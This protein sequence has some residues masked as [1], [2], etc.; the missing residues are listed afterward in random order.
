MSSL[1]FSCSISCIFL[2]LFL[3]RSR[4]NKQYLRIQSLLSFYLI[5]LAGILA[6]GITT[7]LNVN[8]CFGVLLGI[9]FI[10]HHQVKKLEVAKKLSFEIKR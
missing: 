2:L 6:G 7:S 9:G 4:D 3:R 10:L 5:S 8:Y 1:L